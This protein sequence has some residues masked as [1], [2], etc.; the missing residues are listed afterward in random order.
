MSNLIKSVYFN[1][2]P[3]ERIIE[4]DSRAEK[5]IPEI[6]AAQT[7]ADD[8]FENFSFPRLTEG[9]EEYDDSEYTEGLNVI[10]V[11]EVLDTERRKLS[12]EADRQG[13]EIISQARIQA[14]EIVAEANS[15]AESI[16]K[17]AYE[18]GKTIGI[19]EGNI[20]AMR[21]LEEQ[22]AALNA[23]YDEMLQELK[24]QEKALEPRFAD[25]MAG[26]IKK[27]TGVVCENK[28]EVIIHLIDNALNNL[29]RT[30][31]ITIRVSKEDIMTVSARRSDFVKY[32]KDDT[33][34]DILEDT[35]LS[36]NQCIIET[37]S[38]I[39]DCSLDAQLENLCEQIK[40]L[41]V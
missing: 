27:I 35:S 4:S 16:K 5:R 34:F 6:Y 15:L 17:Q 26:L 11:N 29:E 28:K 36:K 1:M 2:N 30:K 39:I 23:E 13:E 32:L 25:I 8:G 33:E 20:Q 38:K 10:N 21:Q 12:E 19:E 24:E 41:A 9:G 7:K 14:D 37:D 18:E 3:K 40:M 22:K 31:Q